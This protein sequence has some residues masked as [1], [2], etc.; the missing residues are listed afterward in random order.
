MVGVFFLGC[1]FLWLRIYI[2]P[3]CKHLCLLLNTHRGSTRRQKSVLLELNP[4]PYSVSGVL[5]EQRSLFSLI[6][7]M[8]LPFSHTMKCIRFF[9][10]MLSLDV[11]PQMFSPHYYVKTYFM[12]KELEK[13]IPLL[14][15]L[16]L[17]HSKFHESHAFF[18]H[19]KLCL[20]TSGMRTHL[21]KTSP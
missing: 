21:P 13:S 2:A 3:Q 16:I 10:I 18:S 5:H 20:Q 14:F 7:L 17:Y 8:P 1:T 19:Y 4:E 12:L 11:H 9:L 15:H 6:T